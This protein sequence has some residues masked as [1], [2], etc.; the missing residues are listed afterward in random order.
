[1]ILFVHN[2]LDAVGCELVVRKVY[3]PS[4]TFYTNYYD[5]EKVVNDIIQ[6]ANENNETEIIIADLSFAERPQTLQN[7]INHFEKVTHIDHHSYPA[8]FFDGITGNYTRYIDTSACAAKHCLKYFSI[9]DDF[10][11]DLIYYID[12]Y[13]VWRAESKDFKTAQ[14]LNSY[15]WNKGY[16]T[17]L[18]SFNGSY[19]D[20]YNDVVNTILKEQ[21]DKIEK[22]KNEHNMLKLDKI[23]FMFTFEC[24]NPI[25]I[26]EME[27][28]QHFVAGISGNKVRFRIKKNIYTNA[29]MDAI[30]NK[31]AGKTTGHLTAFSY[32]FDGDIVKER[33]RICKELGISV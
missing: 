26:D 17:F 20:D 18:A 25:M 33:N 22:I 23:T 6:Y 31:I 3:T 14:N 4:K 19:P 15:F 27:N 2:D 30:R 13:D 7:L 10:L 24:F 29:E 11:S 12:I 8:G 9:K 32:T 16:Q 5:F 1:M 21:N 28:G